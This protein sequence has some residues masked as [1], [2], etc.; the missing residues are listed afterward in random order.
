MTE[1]KDCDY[2]DIADWEEDKKTGKAKPIY[3]CERYNKYC[4]DIKECEYIRRI[5][6]DKRKSL[7][8]GIN[9]S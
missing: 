7:N 8:N 5:S 4:E 6:N 2:T 3:W 9:D 1:C